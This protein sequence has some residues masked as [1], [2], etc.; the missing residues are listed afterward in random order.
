MK[1]AVCYE[2]G[3]PLII[4]NIKI[5]EPKQQEIKVKLIS[6]A[7]CHSDIHY[8]DGAW[9]GVL[10]AVYGHEAAGIVEQVGS[11]VQ[12][13]DVGN[14]V[15]VSLMRSCGKCFYCLKG[16]SFL[17]EGFFVLDK[18]TRL[19]TKSGQPIVQGLR[20]GAFAE[21]VV[22][23]ESQIVKIPETIPLESASLLACGV[24]T[25]FGAVIN[26]TQIEVGSCVVVIGIGG[27]GLNTIQGALFAGAGI[28]I[29]LDIVESKLSVAKQ[30]GAT[31]VINSLDE[32][33]GELVQLLTQ[34]RG[35]D[36]VFVTVGNSQAIKQ[37]I[38]LLRRGG[39]LVLV[40]MPPSGIEL[41]IEADEFANN[42]QT[43]LGSKMGSS[44]LPLDIP[45][46]VSLYEQGRLKLDELITRRYP[47][48]KINDAIA[49]VKSGEA[50][51]NV[52]IFDD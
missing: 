24:I 26:T 8:M 13:V 47:L 37:G 17:C 14:H 46:L 34:G 15:V 48:E 31:H 52:I 4:E 30:F 50:I 39:S 25:G 2:F 11:G 40:G 43:I 49:D 12:N 5:D 44:R 18:E 28:I 23:D 27:V 29:A 19:H 38:G 32:N 21:Y 45:K 51:R 41:P 1:A 7:I 16:D 20:V 9:G 10:P 22:V 33:A 36:Y 3:H 6:C 42:N 35:A